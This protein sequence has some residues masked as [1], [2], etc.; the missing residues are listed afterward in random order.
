MLKAEGGQWTHRQYT[1]VFTFEPFLFWPPWVSVAARAPRWLPGRRLSAAVSPAAER[2][3]QNLRP[4]V[5]SGAQA[6][7]ES[8]QTRDQTH[9]PCPGEQVLDRRTTREV[10]P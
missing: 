5:A 4:W 8:S 7:V 10:P 3:L 2:G 6:F 1:G 9:M